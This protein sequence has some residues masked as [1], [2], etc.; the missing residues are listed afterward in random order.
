MDG[1][2]LQATFGMPTSSCFHD[3]LTFKF[4]SLFKLQM[5]MA[6]GTSRLLSI[7]PSVNLHNS[8]TLIRSRFAFVGKDLRGSLVMH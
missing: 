2:I 6:T 8:S 3:A 7:M 5:S 1:A 4:E